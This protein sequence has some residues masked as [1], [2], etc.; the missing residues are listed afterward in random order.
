MYSAHRMSGHTVRWN[1]SSGIAQCSKNSVQEQTGVNRTA[2]RAFKGTSS[3]NRV[4]VVCASVRCRHGLRSRAS[5][6]THALWQQGHSLRVAQRTNILRLGPALRSAE[7]R[8]PVRHSEQ[9][10]LA[11]A[12]HCCIGQQE[13]AGKCTSIPACTCHSASNTALALCAAIAALLRIAARY[14]TA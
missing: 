7:I 4:A 9:K 11:H 8:S 6:T 10:M 13:R 12:E 5:N 14:T 2:L 1:K 3:C